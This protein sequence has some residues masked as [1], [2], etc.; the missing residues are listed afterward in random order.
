MNLETNPF[1]SKKFVPEE[2]DA[3][4]SKVA[5]T[6]QEILFSPKANVSKL[7]EAGHGSP[8]NVE[9]GP[10]KIALRFVDMERTTSLIAVGI[11]SVILIVG[12]LIAGFLVRNR[13]DL[14]QWL[15]FLLWFVG[16]AFG[17][18]A[19]YYFPSR[20]YQTTTWQLKHNGIAIRRGIWWQH[21]IFIPRER[22]QHTDIKQGP[23]MRSYGLATLVINTG[24]THEPSI[25]LC[26]I[27]LETAETIRELLSPK[28]ISPR[29]IEN[30]GV[31]K[32]ETSTQ[33]DEEAEAKQ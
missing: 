20:I 13:F 8:H 12:W 11:V 17:V 5:N 3:L 30:I 10:Q 4:Q 32:V 28:T 29:T 7:A 6:A 14:W 21:R 2:V 18:F 16:T 23:L 31:Q 1:D 27:G 25:P 22:I 26:G 15:A 9:A 33:T 24:G 19:S